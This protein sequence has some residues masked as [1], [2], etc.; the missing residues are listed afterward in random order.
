MMNN[1]HFIVVTS[2]DLQPLT[3]PLFEQYWKP[4]KQKHKGLKLTFYVSPFNQEFS[5]DERN[6]IIYSE[7]FKKW[8][9]DNKE[10]CQ[11]EI[12]GNTHEKPPENQR[13][14]EEQEQLIASSVA[15]M[16]EYL[17]DDC[18]GYKATFYR[19]ND[20][21]ITVLRKLGFSW[22]SQWWSLIPLKINNKRIPFYIEIGTHTNTREANNPDNIDKVYEQLDQALTKYEQMGF[23][24]TTFRDIMKEVLK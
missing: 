24:Y 19:A 18:L 12:H 11:V 6:N 20:D 1:P 4:L 23:E 8:Y 16:M 10:W 21:M 3:L 22:F 2:D 17:D 14:R 5:N 15:S 9:K 13:T 7:E